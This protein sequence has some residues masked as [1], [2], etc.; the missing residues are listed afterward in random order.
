MGGLAAALDLATTGHRV[1]VLDRATGPGGKLR[2]IEVAGRAIDAGPTSLTGRA[3]FDGLFH[4]A[5]EDLAAHLTLHPAATLARHFW[6]ATPDPQHLDLYADRARTA[7][8]ICAFASPRDA[9]GYL[10]LC[11]D[12]ERIFKAL[13]GPFL[14]GARPT[15]GADLLTRIGPFRVARMHPFQTF[16]GAVASRLHDPRLRQLFGQC[17]TR[18]GTSPTAAPAAALLLAHLQQDCWT[19]E[20]GMHRL[21]TALAALAE[22]AGATFRYATPVRE[23][24]VANRRATGVRLE[25]G[26][27]L[28]ADAVVMNGEPAA[29][30]TGLLGDRARPAGALVKFPHRSLSA[31]TWAAVTN[32]DGAP[33]L[34]HNTFFSSN[35]KHEFDLIAGGFLP[36]EPTVQVCAQDRS[37]EGDAQAGPERLLMQISAPAN[38][39]RRSFSQVEIDQCMGGILTLLGRCGLRMT[40]VAPP[41]MTTPSTFHRL[42]PASGGAL[43]GAAFRGWQSALRRPGARTRLR[44]LYLAGGS[45]HPGPGLAFAALSGR[46]AAL[47]IAHDLAPPR[48]ILAR[49]LRRPSAT[50]AI[51]AR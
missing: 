43:Y 6:A 45:T 18:H 35:P 1:T 36:T 46:Q 19:I 34:R 2:E 9:A 49:L 51:P 37:T 16:A 23:I 15:S 41:V 10:A 31:V 11:R 48:P 33:L 39:D 3:V 30:A 5:G 27:I 42:Y 24:V 8:A 28:A 20:G 26:D 14:H 32:V 38:G 40:A 7:D 47:S 29:L 22:R 44:G 25:S 4:R 50:A 17:C 13:D 12:A 21:A